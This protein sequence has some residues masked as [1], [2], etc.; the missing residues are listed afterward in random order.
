MP[1]TLREQ[2]QPGELDL[3]LFETVRGVA[4]FGEYRKRAAAQDGAWVAGELGH[5]AR[6]LDFPGVT[7]ILRKL[8]APTT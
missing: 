6:F 3:E 2:A 1:S 8:F 5:I 4:K 7:E